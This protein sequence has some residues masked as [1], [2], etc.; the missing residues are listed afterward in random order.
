MSYDKNWIDAL[1]TTSLQDATGMTDK[2]YHRWL[3]RQA[4]E[5]GTYAMRDKLAHGMGDGTLWQRYAFEDEGWKS[6]GFV[7]G[8]QFADWYDVETTNDL[9][10]DEITEWFDGNM[11]VI[12]DSPY[13][14]TGRV[15]T[16][17]IHW[18]RNPDGAISYVHAVAMNV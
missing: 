7:L 3:K 13:D 6:Y 4:K 15:F 5:Y 16:R 8:E 1:K 10:D 12:D 2:A 11:R 14:C 17:Y 18:H 9:T